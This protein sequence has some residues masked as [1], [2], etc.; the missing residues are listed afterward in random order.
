MPLSSIAQLSTLQQQALSFLRSRFTNRGSSP[1]QFLGKIGFAWAMG[2]FGV[3]RTL[4][5]IDKDS[6]PQQGSSLLG[7]QTWGTISGIPSNQGGYGQNGAE[8]SSGGLAPVTGT[9]GTV[10]SA[11]QQLLAPDGVTVIEL[12]ADVTIP[13]TGSFS[14]VTAGSAGNLP[15]SAVLTWET[16]PA[17]CDP[18]VTLSAALTGGDDVETPQSLFTRIADHWQ[19]PP[20]GGANI[21]YKTWAEEIDGV[22]EAFVYPRRQGTGTVDV[23]VVG[24]G[25]GT[26]RIPSDSVIDAVTA[27]YGS[28]NIGG[29]EAPT[30]VDGIN[31]YAPE[32]PAS[33]AL[34]IKASVFLQ[35]NYSWDWDDTGGTW[36]VA[37]YS[38]GGPTVTLSATMDP[39][40]KAAVDAGDEPLI[41]VIVTTTGFPVVPEQRRVLS[42]DV[43]QT[44]LTLDSAFTVGPQNGDQVVAG[45]YAAPLIAQAMLAFVDSLGPSRISGY[46]DSVNVWQDVCGVWG[47]GDAAV[48]ATDADGVT[49]LVTR[50]SGSSGLLIAVGSGGFSSTDYQ[51][52][53][54][55]FLPPQ[56]AQAQRC[57][58]IR[59]PGS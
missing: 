30:D 35:P 34:S 58:A 29:G 17:G 13:A 27:A 46:A 1:A 16:P 10:V 55:Y 45:A 11:G 21:D 39:T 43:T 56:M 20:K 38:A 24:P 5:A 12:D 57:Y 15:I 59:A 37:G 53:D 26:G 44:I 40:L 36:T 4:E 25:S 9:S 54:T 33:A 31:V 47:A 51:P 7:L 48:R 23:V 6:P 41:Q 22:E 18:T 52:P 19:Q 28:A 8:P 49:R 3:Q 50:L 2:L 14:A 32:M 42:Y